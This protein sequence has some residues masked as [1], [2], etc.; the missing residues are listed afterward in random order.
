VEQVFER[1]G[2]DPEL[3]LVTQVSRYDRFKDPLGVIEACRMARELT[4]LQLVLAGGG[5][6]DDPEGQAVLDEVQAAAAGDPHTH[7]LVLPA[8]AHRTINALQR[9]S[10]VIMQKSTKEGFGLTVS[11]GLWKGKPVIGGDTGGIRIQVVDHFTG[12][13]V[14]SPEGAALRLRY[15]L[16]NR[17]ALE[18]MGNHA[19][20]FVRENFLNTRHL[21]EYLTLMHSLQHETTDRIMITG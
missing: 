3:P 20:E 7:I 8:D 21:R 13:K 2:L 1:F 6:T 18:E 19:H 16:H 11:E 4:P 17:D 9:A 14:R 12:F 15:L 10:M 5:A